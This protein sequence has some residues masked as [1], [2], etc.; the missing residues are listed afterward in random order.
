VPEGGV[1]G[2]GG[3]AAGGLD[4]EQGGGSGGTGLEGAP[5]AAPPAAAGGDGEGSGA[6]GAL[7]DHREEELEQLV[8]LEGQSIDCVVCM[9]AVL[10]PI[11]R[12]D[13]CATPCDHVFHT[14]CLMPWL[15]HKMECPT[16]RCV[17]SAC[18]QQAPPFCVPPAPHPPHTHTTLFPA[19]ARSQSPR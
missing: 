3:G 9:D 18:A 4:A 11:K 10:F 17:A 1:G 14:A 13:Y 2:V 8:G 19:G 15:A 16:C 5:L 12:R 6:G 7:T